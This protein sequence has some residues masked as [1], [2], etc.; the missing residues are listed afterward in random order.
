MESKF[1]TLEQWIESNK[2]DINKELCDSRK[3]E[4]NCIRCT[5]LFNVECS[6]NKRKK[7][8]IRKWQ[9]YQKSL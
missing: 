1:V 2:N 4:K 3:C 6:Y 5:R 9:E 7:N 8:D